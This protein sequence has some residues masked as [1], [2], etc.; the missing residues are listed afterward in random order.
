MSASPLA[1]GS[2]H[3]AGAAIAASLNLP[4]IASE[5]SADDLREVLGWLSAI[6]A[7]EVQ[8]AGGQEVDAVLPTEPSV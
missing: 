2:D 7:H 5:I 4:A 8:P 6:H 1:P 3:H